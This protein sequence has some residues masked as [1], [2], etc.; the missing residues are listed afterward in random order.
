[1][2]QTLLFLSLASDCTNPAELHRHR[3]RMSRLEATRPE[4]SDYHV[5]YSSVILS[6][7][8]K[9]FHQHFA[10]PLTVLNIAKT[11]ILSTN[12]SHKR[13]LRISVG[14][15][16]DVSNETTHE[17]GSSAGSDISSQMEKLGRRD[18]LGNTEIR[19]AAVNPIL[20]SN[21]DETNSFTGR[22]HQLRSPIS[23]R[24]PYRSLNE[25]LEESPESSKSQQTLC[26]TRSPDSP[27]LEHEESDPNMVAATTCEPEMDPTESVEDDA[28][29]MYSMG[30]AQVFEARA[31]TMTRLTPSPLQP[32]R[33]VLSPIMEVSR[34]STPSF[35]ASRTLV[36]VRDVQ[37][38][39][40]TTSNELGF[41]PFAE[42]SGSSRRNC[43]S[44]CERLHFAHLGPYL[45]GAVPT[46]PSPLRHSQTIND[47][48]DQVLDVDETGNLNQPIT[49]RDAPSMPIMSKPAQDRLN[50]DLSSPLQ[51]PL[52]LMLGSLVREDHRINGGDLLMAI[53][54]FLSHSTQAKREWFASAVQAVLSTHDADTNPQ[55]AS[56]STA[57]TSLSTA[58][59]PSPHLM[60]TSLSVNKTAPL[61]SKSESGMA[62]TTD[63]AFDTNKD[64]D[65]PSASLAAEDILD[66][67]VQNN[68]DMRDMVAAW[69]NDQESQEPSSPFS[70]T[71]S[72]PPS[73]T[74]RGPLR[75]A[76][77]TSFSRVALGNS[78]APSTPSARQGSKQSSAESTRRFSSHTF[79]SLHRS[80][81]TTEATALDPRRRSRLSNVFVHPAELTAPSPPTNALKAHPSMVNL[82][83]QENEGISRLPVRKLRCL[84][85]E[86]PLQCASPNLPLRGNMNKDNKTF[87]PRRARPA[88]F[89]VQMEPTQ[90]ARAE[91]KSI[92]IKQTS[93]ARRALQDLIDRM[94]DKRSLRPLKDFSQNQGESSSSLQAREEV[95]NGDAKDDVGGKSGGA[96]AGEANRTID[97]WRLLQ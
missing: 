56:P 6:Y 47:A 9:M 91:L 77:T 2:N 57:G 86:Q 73:S 54:A 28:Q 40:P 4:S 78:N 42:D 34:E 43:Q 19:Q 79:A 46:R 68:E 26:S 55:N 82:H 69:N 39:S 94:K 10:T 88:P 65:R 41:S 30:D 66:R 84:F 33:T 18:F 50:I 32:R 37:H 60:A 8:P 58:A 71:M 11:P 51:V 59:V 36:D 92:E 45:F 61:E 38:Q 62:E 23:Q 1:M 44:P 70:P 53:N 89:E 22:L 72:S 64:E 67:L 16:S 80:L 7:F 29:S 17:D 48:I 25:E 87:V 75:G 3:N 49:P 35:E 95:C 31:Q 85:V 96:Q 27:V 76:K 90:I 13:S 74:E 63:A 14:A 52:E 15:K 83:D 21:M 97:V 20:S 81:Q 12:H 93:Q 24:R 5:A